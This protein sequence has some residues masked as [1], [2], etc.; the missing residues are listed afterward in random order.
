MKVNPSEALCLMDKTDQW[1]HGKGQDGA[2]RNVNDIIVPELMKNGLDPGQQRNVDQIL[3]NLDGTENKTKLGANAIL[4][5]SMAVCKAG[6]A[7]KGVPLYKHISDLAG[8]RQFILP[9]PVFN[10]I[11]GGH[12]TGNNLALEQILVHPTGASTFSEAM[13]WGVAIQEAAKELVTQRYGPHQTDTYT[14]GGISPAVADHTDALNLTV[15]AIKAAGYEGRC[16]IAIDARADDFYKDNHYN[17]GV[18]K[19]KLTSE[20]LTGIYLDIINN[21]PIDSIEQ[22]FSQSDMGAWTHLTQLTEGRIKIVGDDL[23]VTNSKCIRT[24]LE[25]KAC[26]AV[27]IKVTQAGT[28]TESIDAANLARENGWPVLVSGRSGIG[29]DQVKFGA[30]H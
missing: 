20:E 1:C 19:E 12:F 11:N 30:I 14:E 28:V 25:N 4:G 16:Q 26:N 18:G 3:L 8:V 24:A 27:S 2:I 9:C 29:A 13:Q 6:A 22:P 7:V 21:Y 15:D 10:L 5:A 17:F 23:T